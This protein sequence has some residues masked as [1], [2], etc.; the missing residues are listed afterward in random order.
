MK[1]IAARF[2]DQLFDLLA[3][4]AQLEETTIVDQI[5]QAVET[6]L[7]L[8][9]SGGDLASRAEAAVDE[10]DREAAAKK[11]AIAGLIGAV[12]EPGTKPKSTSRRRPKSEP[13]QGPPDGG[14]KAKVIPIGFAPNRDRK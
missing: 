11:A 6:H 1:T 12:E 5:R 7:S 4:V 3:L 13:D 8:K 14:P 2:D 9:L 10:I